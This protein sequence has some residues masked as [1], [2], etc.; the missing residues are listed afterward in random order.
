M[1]PVEVCVTS[2]NFELEIKDLVTEEKVV[3]SSYIVGS[4]QAVAIIP[5]NIETHGA[6]KSSKI[7][8]IG[9]ELGGLVTDKLGHALSLHADETMTI[10]NV[11][12]KGVSSI[13]VPNK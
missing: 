11:L 1:A 6:S 3:A 4:H 7:S 8:I 12:C 2:A 10:G 5:Q 9:T 13:H